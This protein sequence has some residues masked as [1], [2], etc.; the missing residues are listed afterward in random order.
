[1]IRTFQTHQVRKTVELSEKLWDFAPMD[2]VSKGVTQKVWVPSCLETY[3]GM[4]NYRGEA[5]YETRFQAEGTIRICFKGVSHYAKV[6][7]DGELSAEHY[8]SYGEF[9]AYAKDLKAGTHR[10]CVEV[11]NQF[12]EEY[13]LDFPNDY[14][15]Y[16]GISRGVVLEFL[17]EVFVQWVHVTPVKTE[18]NNWKVKVEVCCNN[19]TAKTQSRD[20]QIIVSESEAKKDFYKTD[21]SIP[22]GES[23]VYS[24]ILEIKDGISWTM[25]N[26]FLYMVYAQLFENGS[27]VDD[28]IDRF[29]LRTVRIAGDKILFNEKTVQIKGICRHEDHPDYGCALPPAVIW[30]DLK[31]IKNLG[32]NSV[33][34][35]HYPN[36]E[37]FLDMCD[38]LGILAW[39]ESHAR[40]L[41]EQQMRNPYFMEQSRQSIQEMIVHHYN[42]PSI[43]I[44]GML[45]E[46]ASE[47]QYGRQCYQELFEW[48][49][50]FDKSRPKSAAT[51]KFNEDLCQDLGDVC[52]WN[53]YP[54]WYEN[55]TATERIEKLREWLD[56]KGNAKDKPL[57]ITEVGA[58]AVYG[59]R[60]SAKD[61][62]SEELQE[63][64]LKKQLTEIAESKYCMGMYIWQFCDVRVSREWAMRRPKSRNNK[65]IVDEYRR[66]K[67]SAA[68]VKEIFEK[69]S[70]Y[71][72]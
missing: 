68:S 34:T 50:L 18:K 47:T 19:L 11:D 64:I 25:D 4:E 14:Y 61:V 33:R 58:G 44:W 48:M 10:L 32:A 7:I 53:M 27:M 49:E 37:I 52:A 69:I 23:V 12:R 13:S 67:L 51:C 41:N 65:G 20:L 56:T 35:V 21:I 30:N 28:L 16:G 22:P 60:S 72:D 15:S 3:P 26:A 71:R 39:E 24:E 36:D 46:C 70:N 66:P 8:G 63:E 1:V 42:H 29:G 62:W 6:W 54:Y 17:N 9:F 55:D 59:F 40:A 43:Y 2:G 31:M 38:E 45:N 5:V 57:L